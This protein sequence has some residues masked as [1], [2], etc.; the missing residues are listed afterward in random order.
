MMVT[1][2]KKPNELNNTNKIVN[3]KHLKIMYIVCQSMLCK[4]IIKSV[5]DVSYMVMYVVV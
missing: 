4:C 1:K 3:S 5:I 2:A